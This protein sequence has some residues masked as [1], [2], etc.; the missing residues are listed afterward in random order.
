VV[1]GGRSVRLITSS[2]YVSRLS[3][4]CGSLDVSQPY[5]PPRS[6]TRIAL[7]FYPR[8]STLG[9]QTG[10]TLSMLY[11]LSASVGQGKSGLSLNI[12]FRRKE[13]IF[14]RFCSNVCNSILRCHWIDSVYDITEFLELAH[15]PVFWNNIGF[16]KLDPFPSSDE[17][18]RGNSYA[19]YISSLQRT[20]FHKSLFSLEYRMI[21]KVKKKTWQ[22][23]MYE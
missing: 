6:V 20:K 14:E 23:Q 1:K 3:R 18:M 21:E 4:K 5:G 22:S 11:R 12:T 19:G 7:P 2:P 16:R 10:W 9:S 17:G 15:R 13:N 8:L